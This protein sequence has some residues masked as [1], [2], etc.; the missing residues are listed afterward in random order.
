MTFERC[1][2][3]KLIL[4]PWTLNPAFEIETNRSPGTRPF[5]IQIVVKNPFFLLHFRSISQFFTN[6]NSATLCEKVLWR[7][8]SILS[9]IFVHKTLYTIPTELFTDFSISWN[10]PM[11]YMHCLNICLTGVS[12]PKLYLVVWPICKVFCSSSQYKGY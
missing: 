6:R 2:I 3:K 1:K 11:I 7:A 4:E 10:L 9:S 8:K 5:T 12:S